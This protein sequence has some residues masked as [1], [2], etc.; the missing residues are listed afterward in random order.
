MAPKSEAA[1]AVAV[2]DTYRRVESQ[3]ARP[4]PCPADYRDT[5]PVSEALTR[6]VKGNSVHLL[7][8]YRVEEV[9]AASKVKLQK[10]KRVVDT[11][12]D[13]AGREH[14]NPSGHASPPCMPVS[15]I[16]LASNGPMV[17]RRAVQSE[18]R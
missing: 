10:S 8:Q 18:R 7:E 17:E 12:V 14:G 15:S 6:W 2:T 13:P 16:T 4:V 5:E 1:T 9:L 3:R 11:R